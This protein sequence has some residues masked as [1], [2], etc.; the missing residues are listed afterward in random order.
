MLHQVG[1]PSKNAQNE[2]EKAFEQQQQH[3]TQY[4]LTN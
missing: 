4:K 1:V 2:D 3:Q